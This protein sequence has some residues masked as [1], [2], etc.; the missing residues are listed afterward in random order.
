[1]IVPIAN[2]E[3]GRMIS[4]LWHKYLQ[5][6]NNIKGVAC[7]LRIKRKKD[8]GIL[9]LGSNHKIRLSG[10]NQNGCELKLSK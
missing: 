10:M 9:L 3:S 5:T 2:D 7:R 1:M 8:D 4:R 6:R